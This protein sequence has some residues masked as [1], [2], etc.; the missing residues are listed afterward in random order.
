M[1]PLLERRSALELRAVGDRITGHA[2]VFDSRS[3]DLGGFVEVI[4]PQA[5]DR[6]LGGDVVALYNHDAGAV[7]GRTPKTLQLRKDDRG[8][9][10]DLQPPATQVGREA[11]EL[12]GRGDIRG[13][14]FGFKTIK[15]VWSRKDG[16]TIRELLDIEIVEISLTAIPV[17][18]ETD[19]AIAQRSLQVFQ[20][21]QQ[22]QSIRWLRMR[23]TAHY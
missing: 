7:L 12:V 23:D 4:R 15:D 3:R 9:A 22:G 19:V 21:Q 17:Y 5:V 10:F 8:L 14:S 20:A 11:V 6:S 2:I 18:T 1:A 16:V 13:A